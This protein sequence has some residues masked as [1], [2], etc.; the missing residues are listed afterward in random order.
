MFLTD[1]GIL[2]S[3][4]ITIFQ[5]GWIYHREASLYPDSIRFSLSERD[6]CSGER[7]LFPA[8]VATVWEES[9]APSNPLPANLPA[10][11]ACPA[12]RLTS[13]QGIGGSISCPVTFFCGDWSWTVFYGH[14]LPSAD[15]RRAVV[16]FWQ[17]NAHKFWSEAYNSIFGVYQVSSSVLVPIIWQ[18]LSGIQ[19]SL[20]ETGMKKLSPLQ[21]FIKCLQK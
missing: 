6:S 1:G 18:S 20:K 4:D 19:S 17:K 9:F 10:S 21:D 16:S 7:A 12:A 11:V 3:I 13:G 5:V 8:K 15:L 2:L 14:S